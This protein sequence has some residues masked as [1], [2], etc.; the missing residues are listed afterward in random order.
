[1]LSPNEL[2]LGDTVV[3]LLPGDDGGPNAVLVG[4]STPS[5]P[6]TA[7]A[8]VPD[9]DGAHGPGVTDM[10]AGL[11]AGL[12]AIARAPTAGGLPFAALVFVANPDE[13]IGSPARR[14]VIRAPRR[15]GGRCLVLEC[16]RANGDIVS[17]RKGIVGLGSGPGPRR[18]RRHRAREGPQRDRRGGARRHASSTRSTAAGPA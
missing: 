17:S 7:A 3:A 14:P 11:L 10:K 2:G 18:P 16:A 6:G 4:Q 5:S 15:G 1:M 9:A 13:E 8:A 12:H